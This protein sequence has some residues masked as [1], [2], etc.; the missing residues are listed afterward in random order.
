MGWGEL[1][2]QAVS[3][4]QIFASCYERS[5]SKDV[6]ILEWFDYVLP[7]KDASIDAGFSH[8]AGNVNEGSS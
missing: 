4:G 5:G 1:A 2:F 8:Q 6:R 7:K 3:A